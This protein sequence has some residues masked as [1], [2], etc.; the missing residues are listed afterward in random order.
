MHVPG[1]RLRRQLSLLAFLTTSA[2]PSVIPC[3]E[4]PPPP[5]SQEKSRPPSK[6]P[7]PDLVRNPPPADTIHQLMQNPPLHN[8]LRTPRYPIV[9]CHGMTFKASFEHILT[10]PRPLWFRYSRPFEISKYANALLVKCLERFARHCPGRGN[11]HF[12]P[13][14]SSASPVLDTWLITVP[15]TSGQVL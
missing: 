5:P 12:S 10:S 9:L 7:R 15:H 8:P 13:W 14:V 11:C 1:L 3:N 6:L 2:Q 4:G